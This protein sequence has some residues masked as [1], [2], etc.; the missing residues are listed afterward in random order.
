[1]ITRYFVGAIWDWHEELIENSTREPSPC[2]I[3]KLLKRGMIINMRYIST[4]G[5]AVP[6]SS[7]EA[8]LKGLAPDG[9]LY[10]PESVPEVTP[11]IIAALAGKTYIEVAKSILPLYLTDYSEEEIGESVELAYAPD[12]FR[13]GEIA[14]VRRI[15]PADGKDIAGSIGSISG[16]Q[17]GGQN[18]VNILE[19]F[20]GP[21]CA[22]KDMALQLTPRLLVKAARDLGEKAETV[23]LVATSGDTGKAALEGFRDVPGTKVIVFYPESGV[24]EVQK[25]Q[26]VTQQG[27][28][29]GVVAVNGNF[30]DAQ[31]SFFT[32]SP[33][34]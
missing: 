17:H 25:L 12:R 33:I 7:K 26:M 3:F 18:K 29:V 24:S 20:H 30:D 4:R 32:G 31:T 10:V 8:I 15:E 1:M 2:A 21:T 11:E 14:P 5:G 6:V 22:F 34:L 28:N 16:F 23:I 9:G 13:D 27:G 19:L